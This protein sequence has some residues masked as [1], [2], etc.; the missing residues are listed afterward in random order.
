M[1]DLKFN[2]KE[3]DKLRVLELLVNNKLTAQEAAIQLNVHIRT[4]RRLKKNTNLKVM[5]P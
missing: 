3:K 5:R 1:D 4:I 2:A